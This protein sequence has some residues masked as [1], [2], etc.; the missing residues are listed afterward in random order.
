MKIA[1]N[2]LQEYILLPQDVHELAK[3]L[4]ALGLEVEGVGKYEQ[5]K[6]S[7]E[8]LVIGE[9]LTCEKHPNADKLSKTTVD[10]GNGTV[11]PI[12]CGAPNVA[13]GQKVVI[14]TV[15]T[16][17]YPSEGE[18]FV[19][20]KAK[21]RGEAS[22]GMICAEDEIGLGQSHAGI[23]VLD[24]E[25]PNGTPAAEYFKPIQDWSIEIGLTP[26]RVDA[27]SHWGVARDLKAL[28]NVPVC[29]PS[30]DDFKVNNQN[31]P[32]EVVVENTEACPRY[33]GV[34]IQ[35]VKVQESPIWLQNRLLAIGIRP[36]NNIVDTTNYVLQE[37]GQPLHAFDADQITGNKV[38]VKTLS[39]GTEFTTLDEV[40]RKLGA[41]DLMIC[42]GEENGMCIGGVFGGFKSGVT[43]ETQNIF[44]ESAYFNPAYIRRTS[45]FHG[46]K[47][48]AS[49]RFERGID[50]N[51]TVYV[52]KRAAL[53]IQELAG[54]E[55]ASE[56]IDLYP[57]PIANF[58]F[59]IKYRNIDR[60]IGKKLGKEFIH[61]TLEHLEIIISEVTEEGFKVS[62]PPY[63]VDVQREA[64][65]IEELARVYGYDNLEVS[66]HLG[67]SYL[68]EFPAK[69]TRKI[70]YQITQLLVSN[71]FNEMY[72]NSLTKPEYSKLMPELKANT[73]VE[74]LNKLSEDLGVMRQTLLFSGLEVLAYNLNRRQNDLKFFEFGKTYH[75]TSDEKGLGKFEENTRLSVFL[76]G[77]KQSDSWQEAKKS[78]TFNELATSVQQILQKMNCLKIDIQVLE[79][80]SFGFGVSYTANNKI[81]AQLGQVTPKL[82]AKFEIKQAVFYADIDWEYLLKQYKSEIV[83]EEISKF[84]EVRRDLSLVLDK[85]VNF[86]EIERLALQKERNILKSL[87]VFD[88]YEGENI[89]QDKKAYALSFI[90]EDKKQTLTDK[91][92]DKTMQKLMQA[93]EQELGAVIRK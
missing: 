52:L 33:A 7:M 92:I 60:L 86:Q 23:M 75:R 55:I 16:T 10:I 89:G 35:G 13:A 17:L 34:S 54:G 31:L 87:H 45:Q 67:A 83:F 85:N 73:Q 32:I 6:G 12:V 62:V 78:L 70:Q 68:A 65:I 64:D 69:D 57:Q 29:R 41:D 93:F 43:E 28:L 48:D 2:W 40:T 22:E 53:M 27:A 84:P 20:K 79:K 26:N 8:G 91:V 42:D 51:N 63:R 49:F 46:L 38:I 59:G 25:L 71:G 15:N 74:V 56:I 4:T 58:E 37:F 21:I 19:I 66:E 5:I 11:S 1:Y 77:N 3:K 9:V 39:A 82:A 76:T 47:T 24:T 81:V 44:L 18:S 72:N 30:V 61:Q 90:L 50:P 80:G 88:V 36:I 14:A